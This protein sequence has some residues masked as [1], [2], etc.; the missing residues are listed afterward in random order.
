MELLGTVEIKEYVRVVELS[1]SRRATYYKKGERLPTKYSDK[2]DVD[3]RWMEHTMPYIGTNILLCNAKGVPVIKNPN[4]AGTP[5]WE[6]I[7][8]QNLHTLTMMPSTRSKIIKA[9]KAQMIPEVEKLAP[10]IKFPIR[11]LCELH[12]TYMDWMYIT[13]EGKAMEI[14]WDLDNRALFYMKVFPDVLQGS[15]MIKDM[16]K[17]GKKDKTIKETVYL[18]K[19]IIPNDHRGYITQAPVPIFTPIEDTKERKLIFKIYHDDREV[20][21]NSKHYGHITNSN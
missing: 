9:I 4:A 15:P 8:G 14:K 7:S 17:K 18:S 1:K 20:I 5:Q 21:K 10:I 6:V 16:G 19:R 11:I 3:Y 12:D 2:I 13:K